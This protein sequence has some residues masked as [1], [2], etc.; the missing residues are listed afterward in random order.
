MGYT[1]TS[2]QSGDKHPNWKGGKKSNQKGYQLL[3]KPDYYKSQASHYVLEHIYVYQEHYKCCMLKWG[4]VHHL[5]ENPSNNEISN[6]VGMTKANHQKLHKEIDMNNRICLI[7]NS[8]TTFIKKRNNRPLWY[9]YN[10]GYIC[11]SCYGKKRHAMKKSF[12]E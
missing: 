8:K 6:L 7:C 11:F 3:Y 1:I 5:D 12:V 2:F 10:N 9:K 4:I